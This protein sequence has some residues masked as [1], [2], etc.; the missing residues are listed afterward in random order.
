MPDPNFV[1]PL[2][3]PEIIEDL[4]SQVRKRL[5]SCGDLRATDSYPRG[6][7]AKFTYHIEC[8][9]LDT[10]IL[11]GEVKSGTSKDDPETTVIDGSND[12]PLEPELNAVRVRSEQDTP[13]LARTADGGE[14]VVG[15]KR[16]Y[17]RRITAPQPQSEA[18]TGG[19]TQDF[20]ENNPAI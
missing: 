16:R 20:D 6:Y 1:A 14:T 4:I 9:G 11:D 2:A 10:S 19:G 7:S 18:L 8:Y 5:Q 12:I 17:A 13:V 3:G 15:Q